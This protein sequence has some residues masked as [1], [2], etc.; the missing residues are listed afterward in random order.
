MCVKAKEG[1]A[2]YGKE[3]QQEETQLD[4][5]QNEGNIKS[6][7]SEGICT[8]VICFF[9]HLPAPFSFIAANSKSGISTNFSK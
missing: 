8:G 1:L 3:P 2:G 7:H 5:G 6:E 9:K 4:D